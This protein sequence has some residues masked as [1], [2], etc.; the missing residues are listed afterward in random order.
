M[1]SQTQVITPLS[2]VFI[3]CEE[4]ENYISNKHEVEYTNQLHSFKQEFSSS[5]AGYVRPFGSSEYLN[6]IILYLVQTLFHI[7]VARV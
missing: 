7:N 3:C 5:S 1:T 2:F 4:N 6:K